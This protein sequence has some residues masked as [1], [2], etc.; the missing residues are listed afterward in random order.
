[1]LKSGTNRS[2]RRTGRWLVA[3]WG[4]WLA[5]IVTPVL[6]ATNYP[7]PQGA[8]YP[9]G[10]KPTSQTQATMNDDVQGV[11]NQFLQ[12]NVTNGGC[13]ADGYRVTLGATRDSAG[14]RTTPIPSP[15][16]GAC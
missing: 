15:S 7:F 13:P 12:Y 4:L 2:Q 8:A 5:L 3:F 6:A 10:I 1:M 11:Y 16:D 14:H 9:F